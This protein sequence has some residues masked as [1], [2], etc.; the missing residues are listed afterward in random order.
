MRALLPP[1]RDSGLDQI[2]TRNKLHQERKEN[3]GH[4]VPAAVKELWGNCEG[5]R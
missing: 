1:Q 4:K 5:E 3:V 2:S